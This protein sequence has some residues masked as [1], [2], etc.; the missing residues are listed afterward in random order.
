LSDTTSTCS[1][2]AN[3]LAHQFHLDRELL[4]EKLRGQAT[5]RGIPYEALVHR[6]AKWAPS[7]PKLLLESAPSLNSDVNISYTE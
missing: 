4:E 2:P 6:L 5:A 7:L 1:R 3:S